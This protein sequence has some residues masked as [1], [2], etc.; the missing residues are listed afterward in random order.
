M[1]F[2]EKCH[3][4][5]KGGACRANCCCPMS[6]DRQFIM[7]HYGDTDPNITFSMAQV[8]ESNAVVALV[9]DGRC[10]FLDREKYSCRIYDDRPEICVRFGD[11]SHPLLSC[12]HMNAQGEE[13]NR[14]HR[15]KLE[16]ALD[17]AMDGYTK[18]LKGNKK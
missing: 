13:R 6:M 9:D 4:L 16:R 8:P 11:E 17:K 15:R 10:V 14:Q 7:A 2:A 12:P 1:N 5:N 18:R 3:N